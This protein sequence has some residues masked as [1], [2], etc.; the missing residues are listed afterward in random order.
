MI[1]HI[2]MWKLKNPKDAAAFK[3][4]LDSCQ[5]LVPGMRQF[6]VAVRAPGLRARYR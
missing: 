3:A 6:E 5:G 1:K 4:R 2:V